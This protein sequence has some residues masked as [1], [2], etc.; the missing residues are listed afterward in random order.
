LNAAGFTDALIVASNELDENVIQSLKDQNAQ[1]DVWG[2]GTKLTTAYDQPALG[3]VYKLS[4]IRER[5]SARWQP[6]MKLSEQVAKISNPGV[7]QVRRFYSQGEPGY[8]S[9]DMIFDEQTPHDGGN[10]IVDPRDFTRRKMFA[11]DELHHD[12][13]VPIFVS[14]RLEY[15]SPSADE[16]KARVKQQL[17]RLH[18]TI[19][20]LLNPHE[21]PVG[22]EQ[23]LHK[24]KTE[25][26]LETRKIDHEQPTNAKQGHW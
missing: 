10:V 12:L 14:G 11:P 3:G 21:Y 16:I 20:R 23:G 15:Q 9:G 25:L 22:L 2:V 8:F 18:P 7:L 26:I 19:K 5:G 1:I 24:L 17:S 6:K 4:A 13:L